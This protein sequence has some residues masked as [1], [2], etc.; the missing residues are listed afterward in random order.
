MNWHDRYV[1]QA[2]WTR[3]LRAYLFDKIRLSESRC[4][5]EVGCGTGAILSK[6]PARPRLHGLDLSPEALQSAHRHAPR[7]RLTRGD[8]HFLPYPGRVFD[9]SYCH[10]LLLWVKN[11]LKA[12][13]EMKRVTKVHG[14]V[15]ALAE[16]D[17][18][19]RIDQ[20]E[21]LAGL[22]QLQTQALRKQ[23][24]DVGL[25][26]RLAQLFSEAG[27]HLLETGPIQNRSTQ[28]A[29]EE[30]EQEWAVLESD[31]AGISTTTEIQRWKQLDQ[32]AWA[33]GR[34]AMYVPTYYAWGQ[35]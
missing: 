3:D 32:E 5:L 35:V 18:T 24:A 28:T 12:L 23:G 31:L 11:P 13:A 26:R 30:R 34:R 1:Q 21:S 15:L 33:Q 25:G 19:A 2:G 6:L 22:G 9:I 4:V 29:R 20:P 27:I 17:Y 7:A 14:F 16:P 10:Y 8:A